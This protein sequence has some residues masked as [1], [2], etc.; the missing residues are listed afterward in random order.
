MK[1]MCC[2]KEMKE[3][4]GIGDTPEDALVNFLNTYQ[5]IKFSQ[6][7][8]YELTLITAKFVGFEKQTKKVTK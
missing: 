8:W 2:D 4:L 6:F 1:Y 3:C 5:P 7:E